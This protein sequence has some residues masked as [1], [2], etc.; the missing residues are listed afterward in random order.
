MKHYSLIEL[1]KYLHNEL[2][3]FGKMR[4]RNHLLKCKECHLQYMQLIEDEKFLEDVRFSVHQMK[5]VDNPNTFQKLSEIFG[6]QY[7]GKPSTV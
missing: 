3:A 4:C 7:S 6:E 1:E 5:G 2:S